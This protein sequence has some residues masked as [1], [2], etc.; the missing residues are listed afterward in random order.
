MAGSGT[1]R[2]D[3]DGPQRRG[4]VR[5]LATATPPA[6]ERYVDLLRA[7][8][9]LVVVL[10]HWTVVSARQVGSRLVGENLL[11]LAPWTHPLT[12]LVQ[13]MPVFFLVGGYA[14]AASLASAERRGVGTAAWLRSRALRLLRPSAVLLAV[15]AAVRVAGAAAGWDEAAVRAAV[16]TAAT[17][18]WF[19][20]VYLVVVCLAPWAERA[21]RRW[22]LGVVVV[23]VAGVAV[24]DVLRL[25][26]A[27]VRPA[28]ASYLLAWLAAHQAGMAWRHG[29]LP[30]S[31]AAAWALLGG[32]LGVALV[33]VGPGPYGVAMV[34]AATPPDL[35]NTAPPTL[36]LLALATAQLGGVLLLRGP[37]TAVLARERVWAGVIAVNGVV[38]SLFLWHMSAVVVVGYALV[39]T[40]VLPDP[41]A[42]SAVWWWWRPLWVLALAIVLAGMVGL[43]RRAERPV[44]AVP[45]EPVSGAVL[46]LGLVAV[47]G[48]LASLGVSDTRGMG[49]QPG[50]LPVSEMAAIAIGLLL[51]ERSARRVATGP[52]ARPGGR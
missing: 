36:A 46:G 1:R 2:E 37:A 40:G 26:T 19:L 3:P 20:V 44:A 52:R 17:P 32:G 31:R 38:L 43:V 29:A 8:S 14:N 23:L 28:S 12:W 6:R 11:D 15:L 50:G 9:I 13:V 33:L 24:G 45:G 4:H 10:G 34:G 25:A 7:V 48:G 41:G 21:H 51:V 27:D 18:L 42:G 22:G 30:R 5:D 49:P 16:W 35:S 47:V 39:R